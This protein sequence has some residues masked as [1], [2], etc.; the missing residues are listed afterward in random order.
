MKQTVEVFLTGINF[1]SKLFSVDRV[2]TAMCLYFTSTHFKKQVKI[3]FFQW[4]FIHFYKD[5]SGKSIR[6]PAAWPSRMVFA[7][8]LT[9]QVQTT[10]CVNYH[11]IIR[12]S[13]DSNIVLSCP[14]F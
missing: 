3:F 10:A 7:L 9:F 6:L 1:I 11:N 5:A 14:I 8:K 13:A 2:T 4:S 12:L